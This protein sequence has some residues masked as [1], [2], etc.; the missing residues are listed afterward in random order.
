[1]IKTFFTYLIALLFTQITFASNPGQKLEVGVEEQL[2][3]YLPL[4]TKFVDEYGKEF[5]LR[6]LFTKPTVLA[7]VY[8]ECPGICSPLM[9]ELADIIN[10]SDLVPGVDYNVITISMD[11]LETPQQALKRKEVFLKTL[12]KNIPPESWKFLTG[13][14]ASIR[15]VSDKAGFFFKREGK[16]FRHAGTFIFVD[17][18]GKV[19]RYL[20][21]SFSERS[22]FGILPFDFKMAILETSESKTAPTI[23]KVLQFC[24]SYKP[25][26][27]TYVL[28]LTRIFGVLI[29]FFVGIF[30][31][32]I[33]FKPK[34]VNVNS[35]SR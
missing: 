13:D 20:F 28:N 17:K 31:L 18:N 22:G 32:Y 7:F 9:M 25:E 19:C 21:P 35:N 10:K 23:A 15:A 34:K 33:K 6:E 8:Y 29:L 4:D 16:D 26:S 5:S 12:D 11:E 27:R 24:F 1:M 14:S 3:A 30:L 2:G